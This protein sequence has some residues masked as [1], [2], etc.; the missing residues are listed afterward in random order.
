MRRGYPTN[1]G[2]P[3]SPP[4]CC[5]AATTAPS[6]P[7]SVRSAAG[8]P[9]GTRIPSRSSG[10]RPRKRSSNHSDDFYNG[11]KARDTRRRAWQRKPLLLIARSR[12]RS[13]RCHISVRS[14]PGWLCLPRVPARGRV[15][16]KSCAAD[17]RASDGQ[18]PWPAPVF[19]LSGAAEAPGSRAAAGRRAAIAQR[20]LTPEGRRRTRARRVTPGCPAHAAGTTPSH[21]RPRLHPIEPPSQLRHHRGRTLLSNNQPKVPQSG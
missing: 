11:L 5:S 16:G 13:A 4:T 3:T 6:K 7:W 9:P 14:P 19:G 2:S 12:V 17:R 18:A 10:Q 1:D 20:P 21:G 8:S 15:V